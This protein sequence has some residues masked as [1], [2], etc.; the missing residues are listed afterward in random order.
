MAPQWEPVLSATFQYIHSLRE[1]TELAI[2]SYQS[3]GT[4]HLQPTRHP[5]FVNG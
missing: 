1:G 2:V 5:E 3:E 4:V